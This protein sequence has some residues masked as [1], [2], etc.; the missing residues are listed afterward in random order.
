MFNLKLRRSDRENLRELGCYF[1]YVEYNR[2]VLYNK[3]GDPVFEIISSED[4]D[5]E[6]I[7]VMTKDQVVY[8]DAIGVVAKPYWISI[9]IAINGIYSKEIDIVI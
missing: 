7:L 2:I 1:R 9:K 5:S 6:E 4:E 3:D 8:G